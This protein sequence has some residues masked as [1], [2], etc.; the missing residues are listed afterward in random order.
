MESK[1][2]IRSV[3][4]RQAYYMRVQVSRELKMRA[5]RR[6]Y[7]G[8]H[9]KLKTIRRMNGREDGLV[10]LFS[11]HQPNNKLTATQSLVVGRRT[12]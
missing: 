1:D 6:S 5:L 9:A 10:L 4:V 11:R 8:K 2:A 12:D 7:I 3:R